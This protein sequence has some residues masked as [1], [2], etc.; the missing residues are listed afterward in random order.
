MRRLHRRVVA[1]RMTSSFP[2][3]IVSRGPER[4][5]TK[6]INKGIGG[7]VYLGSVA[8]ILKKFAI[9]VLQKRHED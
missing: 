5:Y 8:N 9:V 1:A 2:F 4:G 6:M 3:L 7:N